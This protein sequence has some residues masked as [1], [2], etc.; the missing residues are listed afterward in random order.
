MSGQIPDNPK[1]YHIVHVDK[2]PEILTTGGLLCDAEVLRQHAEGTTIGMSHI[3]SRRLNELILS[4]F[5]DLHIGDCVPF[6][7]CP[8]SI[9]LYLIS[10]GNHPDLG[11]T[12]G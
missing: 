9:M 4:S 6:Y 7:F 10:R 12:D 8:R 2:L 1:I 5:P 3:K 11:Y